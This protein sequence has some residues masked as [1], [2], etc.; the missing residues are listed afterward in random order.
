MKHNKQTDARSTAPADWLN[1]ANRQLL[2]KTVEDE[3]YSP[4]FVD[5]DL[6]HLCLDNFIKQSPGMI[7]HP[8]ALA[9]NAIRMLMWIRQDRYPEL[10]EFYHHYQDS[11][12]QAHPASSKP[13]TSSPQ[14]AAEV[15]DMASSAD[16]SQVVNQILSQSPAGYRTLPSASICSK[17]QGP[18]PFRQ[19]SKDERFDNLTMFL[20]FALMTAL[21]IG[22]WVYIHP[23]QSQAKGLASGSVAIFGVAL[24][25]YLKRWHFRYTRGF[26]LL[27]ITTCLL[28]LF[29]TISY[30]IASLLSQIL[31]QMSDGRISAA[32]WSAVGL[33]LTLTVCLVLK[34]RIATLTTAK[35]AKAYGW[36]ISI[37][38]TL[39]ISFFLC[40]AIR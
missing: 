19:L 14:K 13:S 35:H 16:I 20:V 30:Q 27:R 34:V 10:E 22:L 12:Q 25:G 21:S 11:F 5:T 31:S 36:A 26:N 3:G 18:K 1:A 15:W 9:R 2:R 4:D 7:Y 38:L 23:H 32:Q 6:F 40:G 39:A 37:C 17:E 33:V 29:S 8:E 24:I 28:A